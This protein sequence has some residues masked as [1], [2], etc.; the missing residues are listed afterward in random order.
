MPSRRHLLIGS[1][2]SAASLVAVRVCTLVSVPLILHGLGAELYGVWVLAGTVLMAQGL[3]DLGMSSALLRFASAAATDDSGPVMRLVTRRAFMFYALLS[4]AVAV[5]AVLLARPLAEALPHISGGRIDDAVALI[6]YAA[7]GFTLTNLS[8]VFT[9][10][11]Q[12]SDRVATAFRSQTIGWLLYLPAIAIGFAADLG[13]HAVGLAWTVCFATQ[14]ALQAAPARRAITSLGS[15]PG[16]P[17]SWPEMLSLG[18][19]WQVS[20]W[21]DFATFQ[22][23]RVLGV[24]FLSSSQLVSLDVALRAATL[25]TAPLF[26][27]FPVVLPTAARVTAEGGLAALKRWLDPLYVRGTIAIVLATAAAAPL[28]PSLLALWT[29]EPIE[30]FSLVAT[31]AILV[32]VVAHASTGLLTNVLL[33]R[34]EIGLVLWLKW[35][36]FLTAAVLLAPAAAIGIEAVAIALALALTVPAL[37]FNRAAARKFDLEH[38]LERAGGYV[39]VAAMALLVALPGVPVAVLARE[40]ELSAPAAVAIG[41]PIAA[42]CL[43]V[44]RPVVMRAIAARPARPRP[45]RA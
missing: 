2:W 24:G 3:V 22:L 32:G 43:L 45:A 30:S 1:G 19:R 15:G 21:A 16:S 18:G 29:G 5:P 34:G 26:A 38:P 41:V 17:P 28:I 33:A 25:V 31:T 44:A 7:L 35:P 13:V 39:R 37:L 36:Q 12:G 20:A 23:P 11:L 10:V 42:A 6:R 9:V 27:F 4:L 8:L 40:G 14:L